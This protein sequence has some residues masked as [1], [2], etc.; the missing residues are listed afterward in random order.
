MLLWD[1]RL[2]VAVARSV[3]SPEAFPK[4]P[5]RSSIGKCFSSAF[6]VGLPSSLYIVCF[7]LR[8]VLVGLLCTALIKS[9]VSNATLLPHERC[10]PSPPPESRP[11]SP[12]SASTGNRRVDD[13]EGKNDDD[14]FHAVARIG[15]GIGASP[16]S[17]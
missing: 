2:A 15:I 5:P 6:I 13:S 14:V 17:R 4:L 3:T 7:R 9:A 1:F 10:C 16:P 12:L 11:Y 8:S